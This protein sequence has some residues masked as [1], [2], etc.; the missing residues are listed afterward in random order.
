MTIRI[1]RNRSTVLDSW[2][3][4]FSR[5]PQPTSE[6]STI[7]RI[8]FLECERGSKIITA[9]KLVTAAVDQSWF[10]FHVLQSRLVKSLIIQRSLW[11]FFTVIN[12][13]MHVRQLQKSSSKG[14]C[15]VLH[16]SVCLLLLFFCFCFLTRYNVWLGIRRVCMI[17][18]NIYIFADVRLS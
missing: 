12:Y 6:L 13:N 16:C 11:D 2:I 4:W 3:E 14:T 5:V 8:Y 18:L 1:H 7:R 15:W 9:L 17:I 10:S